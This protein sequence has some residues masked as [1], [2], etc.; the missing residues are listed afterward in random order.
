MFWSQR[1]AEHSSFMSCGSGFRIK[2]RKGY[3]DCWCWLAGAKKLVM[4]KKRPASLRWNLGSAFWKHKETV[5]Q[6]ETSCWQLYLVMYMNQPNGTGFEGMKGSWRAAEA[7]YYKRPWEAIGEGAAS[8]AING[9]GL[10]G[11]CKRVV[12]WHHEESLWEAIGEA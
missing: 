1:A 9:T 11:S 3:W 2:N 4:I 12:A 7:W 8:V 5:F 6:R 10:K